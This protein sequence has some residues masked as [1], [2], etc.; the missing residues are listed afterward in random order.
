ME[1]K[2]EHIYQANKSF[3]I[4]FPKLQSMLGLAP[5]NGLLHVKKGERVKMEDTQAEDVNAELGRGTLK[6]VGAGF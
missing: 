4:A 3:V 5:A 6:R 1:Q 2:T